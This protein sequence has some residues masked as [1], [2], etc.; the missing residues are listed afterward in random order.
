MENLKLVSKARLGG[1]NKKLK[2]TQNN[3]AVYIVKNFRALIRS[4]EKSE[5]GINEIERRLEVHIN[6]L[7]PC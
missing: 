7:V 2:I 3:D 6:A 4:I 1:K 5:G